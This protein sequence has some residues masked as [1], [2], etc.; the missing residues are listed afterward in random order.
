MKNFI[1][2]LTI[3]ASLFSYNVLA[4][5]YDWYGYVV[6][7][8]G[9]RDT[10]NERTY[11]YG[12]GNN[13]RWNYCVHA[14]LV[15]AVNIRMGYER[16]NLESVHT[17]FDKYF[18]RYGDS[19]GR[20]AGI[21]YIRMLSFSNGPIPD[22]KGTLRQIKYNDKTALFNK[23]K[24]GARYNYPII[25]LTY[26]YSPKESSYR[27]SFEQHFSGVRSF[28]YNNIEHALTIVGYIENYQTNNVN[29]HLV[30]VRDPFRNAPLD[31]AQYPSLYDYTI[32]ISTL[33]SLIKNSGGT[34]DL[35]FIK[36]EKSSDLKSLEITSGHNSAAP[37]PG[38]SCGN[39]LVYDCVMSCVKASTAARWTGDGL[40]DDGTYGMVLTCPAF[41]NDGGDC[42]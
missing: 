25:V 11:E 3:I 31:N 32:P 7:G 26:E 41:S 6:D 39:D 29:D 30:M 21:D 36:T 34:Y 35:M 42:N 16:I 13:N 9:S 37:L 10:S 12:P 17:T 8:S 28:T 20:V 23:I 18:S 24:D 27:G 40:C 33:A 15:T 4:D 38:D 2:S 22:L 19:D 5:V 1:W 14:A